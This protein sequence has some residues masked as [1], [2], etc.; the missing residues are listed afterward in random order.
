MPLR[1]VL[2]CGF[3]L[4][5][6]ACGDGSG[7][8]RAEEAAVETPAP[9]ETAPTP[10]EVAVDL[11]EMKV[12]P[13]WAPAKVESVEGGRR[14][15]TRKGYGD[16]SAVL[17]LPDSARLEGPGVVRMDL[18]VTK[19]ALVARMA[20]PGDSVA[21]KSA[22]TVV[23]AWPES[24]VAEMEVAN[25]NE[26]LSILFANGSQDGASEA[27]IKSVQVLPGAKSVQVGPEAKVNP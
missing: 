9:A 20:V 7:A 6:A 18:M 14:L 8:N 13:G 2:L 1:E 19:G 16:F 23:P 24:Q 22:Q 12:D 25:L 4:T 15:T 26:P 21:S 11:G 5:L 27:I 10:K 3:V 17:D